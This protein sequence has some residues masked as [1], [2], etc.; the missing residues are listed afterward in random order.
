MEQKKAFSFVVE[1]LGSQARLAELIGKRPSTVAYWA[2]TGIPAEAAVALE[3]A[4]DGDIPRWVS[5]PD[6]W[7]HPNETDTAS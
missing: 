4:T 5:R 7:E 1:K 2:N 3:R 6:L